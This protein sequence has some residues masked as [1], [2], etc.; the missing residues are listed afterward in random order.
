MEK[1]K[2]GMIIGSVIFLLLFLNNAGIVKSFHSSVLTV[3]I[4]SSEEIETLENVEKKPSQV[5][6]T[7][8][9]APVVY[10]EADN[11]I[12]IPQ[13]IYRKEWEGKLKVQKGKLKVAEDDSLWDKE[14]AIKEGH[15]F[16]LYWYD[17]K[18]YCEYG[19][20]FT[21]MPIISF[22]TE[23]GY[24]E[25]KEFWTA[26]IEVFDSYRTNRYYQK[27]NCN[28]NIR[29]GTTRTL[30]KKGYKV[31]LLEQKASLL[32][33][34]T[35]DDWIFNALYDDAGLI[36]NKVSLEVW[37]DITEY[38]SVKGDSAYA[39]EYAEVFLDG[40]YHG[41]YLVSE[42]VDEKELDLNKK[43]VLYKC[44]AMRIPEEHNYTNE[45]TDGLQPI[46]LLKYPKEDVAENWEP[47]KDWVNCF[48]KLQIMDYEEATKLLNMEN[49]I[50]YNLFCLLIGG[51]D[52][53]RKN[54]FFTAEYQENG[55]YQMIKNPWDL[56]ATWGNRWTGQ[57]ETNNTT[58]AVENYKNVRDWACDI[59]TL[60][61]MDEAK[62]SSALY[63]RWKELRQEQVIT[64]EKI[65]DILDAQFAYLH[66][67][68]AYKRNYLRWPNGVEYWSDAYIYEYVKNRLE[69]LD[70]YFADLYHDN[71]YGV[72]YGDVDYSNEFEVR[73]YWEANYEVLSEIYDY[74][75]EILL[76][77][78]VQYGKPY[79]MQGRTDDWSQIPVRKD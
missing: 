22:Q 23:N 49:A 34:K 64:E 27:F 57:E 1:M 65:D 59:S 11:I 46:F 78:Y 75:K 28:F 44:R 41:V 14:K 4:F 3:G 9:D 61:Y 73:Y 7:Y 2:K 39:A 72:V 62:V 19:L 10:E 29:G 56:N 35:D 50:D 60:Y 6:M 20:V 31:E 17:E 67:S 71:T 76:E 30:P 79:G 8:N 51:G 70:K 21:G 48:L 47:L 66:D 45:E 33:M 26:T 42:R 69:F 24:D 18:S 16:K 5:M 40:R 43:D 55:K 54:I 13:N 77:H 68:G 12:Y 36:H 53:T 63:E 38:N 52:N 37:E 25:A 74:D 32:G 15:T 58:Y